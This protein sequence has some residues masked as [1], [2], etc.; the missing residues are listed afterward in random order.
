MKLN[1]L[2][3]LLDQPDTGTL[4][5]VLFIGHGTPM[6]AIEDNRFTREM[7]AL[8]KRLEVPKAI[9][10]VSAH[11]ETR[12][13]KVTKQALPPTIHDF[14]GFPR[15]LF[16]TQYPAPGSPWLA[17]ETI[18]QV[19]N[20]HVEMSDQWGFDHG[21]WSVAINL[22]PNANVPMVQLSL[23][24]NKTPIEHYELARQLK[25]LRKKG[26]L[27]IGSGNMVHSFRYMMVNGPDF[28]ASFGHDWV[29]EANA[30]FK[31]KITDNNYKDLANYSSLGDAVRKAIPTPEHYLP[32]LYSLAMRN[33][34]DDLQF[35]NDDAVGGSFT[36][37]SFQLG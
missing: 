33:D 25:E 27:I 20:H 21:A 5:P 23:D 37:T 7:K 17:E 4:M 24:V 10:M 11:W 16:E 31:K 30:L 32:M 6:N 8:G 13:T 22:F 36:M 9:L 29:W 12:G 3:E 28:N 34:K 14:G 15:Q 1:A 2:N 26:V 35:F 18:K 19:P